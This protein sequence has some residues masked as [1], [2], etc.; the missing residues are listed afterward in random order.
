M[1]RVFAPL[2]LTVLLLLPYRVALGQAPMRP[3]FDVVSIRLDDAATGGAGDKFP[4]H[5]TWKWTRIPLSFLV[6]Y[7]YDVALNQVVNVPGKFQTREVA[8]DI[9]AKMAAD[10]GDEQF[11]A[12]LQAMLAD[13]FAFA[14]HREVRELPV[15]A[16]EAAKGGAKLKPA[17]GECVSIPRAAKLPEGQSRCGEVA[18]SIQMKDGVMRSTYTGR[19][20]SVGDLALAL[21]DNGPVVDA[22]GIQGLYDLD[23]LIETPLP[24]SPRDADEAAGREFEYHRV[25]NA[26]FEKQAGLRIDR[27]KLTKHPVPVI[28]VDHV[29]LPTPN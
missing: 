12:M 3:E 26:A 20:I 15:V 1:R 5:G 14:M 25:F 16:I 18:F 21:S 11:R 19:S 6:S 17:S 22:T 13:R 29:E 27:G 28:V 8:F 2:G 7:A 23:V 24:S 9:T 4:S 10:V